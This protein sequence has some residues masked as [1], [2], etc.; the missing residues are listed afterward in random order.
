MP[1]AK[2]IA[3]R[4]KFAKMAKSG[5]FKKKKTTGFSPRKHVEGMK[6]IGFTPQEMLDFYK[7]EFKANSAYE[8]R[9]KERQIA[10]Y[11]RSIKKQR[12]K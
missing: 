12:K 7:D 2:Q 3:W 6:L 11:E 9:F 10:R 1:S 5:K 4:K 8:L